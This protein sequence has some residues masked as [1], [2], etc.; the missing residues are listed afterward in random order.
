MTV[1]LTPLDGGPDILVEHRL[2][3]VGRAPTCD[4][5]LA[6]LRVSRRHCCLVQEGY[7]LFVR[8]L[9]S[10]NGTCVNGRRV[11]LGC[12]RSGDE[13]SIAA[14]R[15]R[16]HVEGDLTPPAGGP[17]GDTGWQTLPSEPPPAAGRPP[18]T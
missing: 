8:D 16:V 6:S 12:A 7:S 1:H 4:V 3:V 13:L 2:V 9:D 14:T 15:F 10:T 18:P 11:R 5:R 17:A